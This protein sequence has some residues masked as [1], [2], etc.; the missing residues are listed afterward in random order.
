MLLPGLHSR[1]HYA[2]CTGGTG[3]AQ[4][5]GLHQPGGGIPIVEIL[6]AAGSLE[7]DLLQGAQQNG[8]TGIRIGVPLQRQLHGGG[9]V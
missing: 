7:E 9:Q 3:A 1:Q 2:H 5:C 4:A 8:K 6:A